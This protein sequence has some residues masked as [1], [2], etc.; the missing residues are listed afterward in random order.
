[1]TPIST[2]RAVAMVPARNPT[3]M[4]LW[5]PSSTWLKTSW[6]RWVVPNQWSADGGCTRSLLRAL[7]SYGVIHGPMIAS[8]T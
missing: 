4:T 3:N 5:V 2:D 6:P 1:V 8:S 7:G